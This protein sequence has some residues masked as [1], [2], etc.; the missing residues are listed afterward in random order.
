S[1]LVPSCGLRLTANAMLLS[2][3][4]ALQ[5]L[6][7]DPSSIDVNLVTP[8]NVVF[9]GFDHTFTSG[10]CDAPV[11][12][13]IIN[14]ILPDIQSTATDGIKGF[15]SDPDG[16]GPQDSPIAAGI[17]SVL[18]GISITGPVGEGLGLQLQSPLFEV[19]EDPAGITLGSDSRFQVS[20]GSGPGQ[21]IPPPGTPDLTASYSKAAAFPTFGST[22][23]VSHAV[24]GMGIGIST[25]GFNQLLRGQTECGLMRT[26]LTTIDLDGSGPAPPV[27]VTSTLLSLIIPE[28]AQLPAD[29]PLRIDIAPTIAPIVTGNAGPN[30]ELTELKIAQVSMK[31]VEPGPEI[32]WL[33]GALDARLGFNLAF[34][35]DG[36]GLAITLSEPQTS[37][38]TISVID[39]PLGASESQVETVLPA[40]V[41]PLIPQLAGALSGFPL[42]QFFG[43]SLQGVEVSRTGQFLAL[44]ANLAAT[45]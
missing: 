7:S 24:Y 26:S 12:G 2:G 31:V 25:A 5:P 4:Y 19:L 9:S 34:L 6:A 44:Y 17:Q 33:E 30:G 42:P 13:D 38:L 41:R 43:L 45:P 1:G 8:M 40:L 3:E 15:L 21:C 14:A 39:N 20:V 37:D 27:A 18:A 36:S 23:P 29:T 16:S 28:F 32:T 11:I 10:I 22:T 35:P